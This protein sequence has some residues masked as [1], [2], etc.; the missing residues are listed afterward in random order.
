MKQFHH[1]RFHA[2]SPCVC[3]VKRTAD[4]EEVAFNILTTSTHAVPRDRPCEMCPHPSVPDGSVE[5]V[6][7]ST[8]SV[9]RCRS[10]SESDT[11]VES[12]V[13]RAR[14]WARLWS[15][16]WARLWSRSWAR[17]WAR[18]RLWSRPWILPH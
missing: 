1:F 11:S 10:D 16:S 6:S 5:E 13:A 12:V 14:S 15:R 4:D 8:A 2:D 7:V 9:K 17:S 18:A 3:F